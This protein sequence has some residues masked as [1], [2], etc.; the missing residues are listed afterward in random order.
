MPGSN[1]GWGYGNGPATEEEFIS[2]YRDLTDILLD[3]EYI[4]GFC[5]TQLYDIEQEKNGLMTYDRHFKFPPETIKKIN[6][7]KAAI[8]K[9]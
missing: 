2:R 4:M 6:S 7:R 9:D 3:N 1:S 5:Y 8:E